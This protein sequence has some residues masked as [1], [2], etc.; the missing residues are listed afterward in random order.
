MEMEINNK[1]DIVVLQNKEYKIR[2]ENFINK[3]KTLVYS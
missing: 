1:L 2:I 3:I